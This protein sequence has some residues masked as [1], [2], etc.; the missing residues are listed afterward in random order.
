MSIK[1]SHKR[2]LIAFVLIVAMIFAVEWLM[3]RNRVKMN[4]QDKD[5]VQNSVN[6]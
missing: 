4:R 5:P 6:K 2:W 1:Q 3:S